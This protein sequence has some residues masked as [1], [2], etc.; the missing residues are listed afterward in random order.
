MILRIA[1]V[2]RE[3][4]DNRGVDTKVVVEVILPGRAMLRRD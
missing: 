4:Y 1:P 3:K 2:D